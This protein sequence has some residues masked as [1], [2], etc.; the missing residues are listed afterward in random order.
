[1]F[2]YLC[3]YVLV[4]T[5]VLAVKAQHAGCDCLRSFDKKMRALPGVKL[6]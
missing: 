3:V 5:Q 1:M 6:L 4:D 2:R